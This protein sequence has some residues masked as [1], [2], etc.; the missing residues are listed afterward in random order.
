MLNVI[1]TL[2]TDQYYQLEKL[3]GPMGSTMTPPPGLHI[4]LWPRVT[5]TFDLLHPSCCD[6]VGIYCNYVPTRFD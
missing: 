3:L 6:T 4:Y 5:L 2:E 1:K